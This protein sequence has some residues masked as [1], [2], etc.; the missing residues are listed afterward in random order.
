[1]SIA[2]DGIEYTVDQPTDN[3]LNL[4]KFINSYQPTQFV[5]NA[6]SPVWLIILGMGY[7]LSTF[8]RLVYAAGQA[9]N[10]ASCSP[11]QLLNLAEIAGTSLL[12]GSATTISCRITAL[13]GG[14]CVITKDLTVTLTYEGLPAVFKPIYAVTIAAGTTETVTLQCTENGPKYIEAGAVTEFDTVVPFIGTIVSSNSAPGENP[15]TVSTL[16]GRLQFKTSPIA[17]LNACITAIRNLTGVQTANLYFNLSLSANLVIETMTIP[18]R[19][20]GMFVQGYSDFIADTYFKY[21]SAPCVGGAV[22]QNFITLAGQILPITYSQPNQKDLY[23]KVRMKLPVTGIA[24]V[25]YQDMI[26]S[27]LLPA[28]NSLLIGED[29]TQRYLLPFLDTF[30]LPDITIMGLAISMDNITYSDTSSLL[31]NEIGIITSSKILF[32]E[33]L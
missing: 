12:E 7:M 15:E 27:L 25:G 13:V 11:A 16:R 14:A 10:I 18:P 2:L 22:T 29:Y 26:K 32:E 28:S 6:T 31:K 3:A 33:I 4:L 17:G 30:T 20:S 21:M 5:V 23:I 24:P 9:F 19:S 1:M 8:Q